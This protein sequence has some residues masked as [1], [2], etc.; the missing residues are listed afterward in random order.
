MLS[1]RQLSH[2]SGDSAWETLGLKYL[3]QFGGLARA[4]A[5]AHL[6]HFNKISEKEIT[7]AD[8]PLVVKGVKRKSESVEE[9][10]LG[11]YSP[12]NCLR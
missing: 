4:E 6:A 8:S 12:H 3:R 9:S 10:V 11:N 7:I 1:L 5:T 2:P